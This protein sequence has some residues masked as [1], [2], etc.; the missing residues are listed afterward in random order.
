MNKNMNCPCMLPLQNKR[1]HD[2][3]L[4][5]K[6]HKWENSDEKCLC[7]SMCEKKR[8]GIKIPKERQ[9]MTDTMQIVTILLQSREKANKMLLMSVVF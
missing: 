2:T 5:D 8:E 6:Y 1:I 3:V 9:K 7:W 4:G